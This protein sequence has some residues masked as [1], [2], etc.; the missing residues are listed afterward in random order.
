M[1]K[2]VLGFLFDPRLEHVVL[3]EKRRPGWQAGKHN[4][5]GGKIEEGE[6]PDQAMVREFREET[7][8]EITTWRQYATLNSHA[9]DFQLN[10]FFAI[11][12]DY[13][14]VVSVT[15]EEIVVWYIS[16]LE[17]WKDNIIPNVRWLIPMALAFTKGERA[18]SF[19]ITEN[20]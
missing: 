1:T 19:T 2:Y 20:Y 9:G 17:L 16:E 12:A 14:K 3:I 6:T 4:G 8:V 15:D 13:D 10:V 11:S 18:S 5:V 7:G